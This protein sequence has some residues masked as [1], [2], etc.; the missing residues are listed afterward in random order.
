[1]KLETQDLQISELRQRAA[2][3]R[4]EAETCA[5]TDLSL[6]LMARANQADC[7]AGARERYLGVSDPV[8]AIVPISQQ[9]AYFEREIRARRRANARYV[10]DGDLN[11]VSAADEIETM[12]AI[13][14]TLKS[15]LPPVGGL[16]SADERT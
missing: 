8:C 12:E 9:I 2:D 10:A 5:N 4:K 11:P 15:A 3:A 13:L 1:V 7:E 6:F 14:A 16:V